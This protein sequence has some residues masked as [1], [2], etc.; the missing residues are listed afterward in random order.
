MHLMY[1]LSESGE[2]KETPAG[3]PTESAHP[4]R[5]SPDDKFSKHR[6]ICKRRFGLLPMQR[7]KEPL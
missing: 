7:A 5:F 3:K 2:R 4:A 6:I 1:Y